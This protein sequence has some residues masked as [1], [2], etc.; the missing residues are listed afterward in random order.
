MISVYF[1]K[2]T[3]MYI[4]ISR[5]KFDLLLRDSKPKL[6]DSKSK[7]LDSKTKLQDSKTKLLDSKSTCKAF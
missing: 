3:A 6:Q 2:I 4:K 5:F 7:L 1:K